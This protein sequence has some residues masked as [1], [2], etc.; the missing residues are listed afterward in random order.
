M[1]K[2]FRKADSSIA[3]GR[4]NAE[5]ATDDMALVTCKSCI[6]ATKD[7]RT[8]HFS[9]SDGSIACGKLKTKAPA[10]T[11]DHK[12]IT[13][14]RC[15][16]VV[17][18]GGS[19]GRRK[20]GLDTKMLRIGFY[21]GDLLWAES[22][23]TTMS[24]VVRNAVRFYRKLKTG[25]IMIQT[26]P[27]KKTI[28]TVTSSSGGTGKTTT[29]RNL[30]AEFARRGKRT[31]LIDLDP[32][33]NLDLFCGLLQVPN[34]PDGDVS[35]IF[36]EDFDGNWPISTIEGEPLE[37]VR[38]SHKMDRIQR[39]LADRRNREKILLRGLK[40]IPECYEVIILDCPATA[41][42]LVD[43]ALTAATHV[44]APIILEEKSIQ[45]LGELLNGMRTLAHELDEEPPDLLGVIPIIRGKNATSRICGEGLEELS[46]TLEFR[47]L[48][49]ITEY[50]DTRKASGAGYPLRAFRP[51]HAGA[52]EFEKLA[53]QI[54]ALLGGK[55]SE[56]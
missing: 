7:R 9:N 32:Q 25:E 16:S 33:V 53:D 18:G 14:Q 20:L 48:P 30:G 6:S 28:I 42:F 21:D 40:T 36:S 1:V 19:G 2:H 54:E 4:A 49:E 51:G 55:N 45:G 43:N 15:R 29:C 41:G 22:Q 46:K 13:C 56:A 34:H 23:S 47:V 26:Y 39:S 52:I 8:V 37:I 50:Q 11:A 31:L 10:L 3:C 38:G 44:V 12:L 35:N 24:E 27:I 17:N 5:N